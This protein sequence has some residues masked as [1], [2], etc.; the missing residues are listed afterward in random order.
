MGLQRLRALQQSRAEDR[1][2]LEAR[3]KQRLKEMGNR[4][5]EVLFF[6]ATQGITCMLIPSLTAKHACNA[7]MSA[8]A[9]HQLCSTAIRGRSASY[10][11]KL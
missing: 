4:L 9:A 8:L 7:A 6:Q 2:V 11:H 5:K 1:A 10:P 3:Y